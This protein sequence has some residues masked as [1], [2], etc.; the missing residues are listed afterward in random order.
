MYGNRFTRDYGDLAPD[1]WANCIGAL[2]GYEIERGL[3][4]LLGR[5]SGTPPTLPQFLKACRDA[6]EAGGIERNHS[7][8]RSLP[9]PEHTEPVHAHAQRCMVA[10]LW[11]KGAASEASLRAMIAVKNSIVGKYKS[12]L[13]EDPTVTGKD[14]KTALFK[15]WGPL[16][17]PMPADEAAHH[18]Q[19]FQR[20]GYAADR[21]QEDFHAGAA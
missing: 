10:Y 6:D 4:S 2:H 21:T 17:K 9:K 8:E 3:K 1:A 7:P 11:E 14:I 18:L 13:A 15:A 12:I 19:N 5:G 20:T 16:W